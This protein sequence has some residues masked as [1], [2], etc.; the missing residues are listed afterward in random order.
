Q[1]RDRDRLEASCVGRGVLNNAA[2]HSPVRQERDLFECPSLKFLLTPLSQ[3]EG[4]D[5]GQ[6]VEAREGLDP[7]IDIEELPA[8]QAAVAAELPEDQKLALES[9]ATRP[10][11]AGK[12]PPDEECIGLKSED[13]AL[14]AVVTFADREPRINVLED[15][16]GPARGPGPEQP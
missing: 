12:G 13:V 8:D 16:F 11:N 4:L 3:R 10:V 6:L 1:R 9:A 14:S 5:T 7:A 2:A 15:R